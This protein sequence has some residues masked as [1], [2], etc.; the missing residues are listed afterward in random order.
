MLRVLGAALLAGALVTAAG[1]EVKVRKPPSTGIT[2]ATLA[3]VDK[4]VE[5]ETAAAAGWQR[6]AEGANVHT[7]D[8]IRTAPDGLARLKYPWMSLTAGPAT[9]VHIPAGVILS[10]VLDEG[11]AELL[12]QGREIIKLRVAEAEIRGEGRIIV[13]REHERTVVMAMALEGSFRVEA[14]KVAVNLLAGEGTVIEDGKAPE[15]PVKLPEPPKVLQPGQDPVYVTRGEAVPLSW[16]PSA[17]AHHIQLLPMGSDEVL[18]E[19]DVE[20]PPQAITFAWLGTF[21]WRVSA[22]DARGIESLPSAPGY[23]CVVEK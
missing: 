15:S 4:V 10:T 18:I 11:R 13:R 8:R 9:V 2:V 14:S 1:R 19:R 12:A 5:R 22:R 3:Y 7:G 17:G 21:R 6:L 20:R 16:S 23:I